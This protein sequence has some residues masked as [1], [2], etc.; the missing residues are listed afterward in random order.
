MQQQNLPK[1]SPP[2]NIKA[3]N[4]PPQIDRMDHLDG[5]Y[6]MGAPGLFAPAA[7]QIVADSQVAQLQE[8]QPIS[9]EQ[10]IL[11][12]VKNMTPYEIVSGMYKSYL[13][14][15]WNKR[16]YQE[17]VQAAPKGSTYVNID[18]NSL[19]AVNDT[20][21]HHAGDDLIVAFGRVFSKVGEKYGLDSLFHVSGDEFHAIAPPGFDVA[22]MMAELENIFQND[23]I[24]LRNEDGSISRWTGGSFGYGYGQNE[25]EAENNLKIAKAKGPKRGEFALIPA[26]GSTVN[27][28]PAVGRSV[29]IGGQARQHQTGGASSVNN[30]SGRHGDSSGR[31][32]DS[33]EFNRVISKPVPSE[34]V[35]VLPKEP[36]FK[37][38]S[39]FGK[40]VQKGEA[41]AQEV[42]DHFQYMLDHEAEIKQSIMDY[43][44]SNDKYKR[45]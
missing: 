38:I 13:T 32:G 37:H 5:K 19:K 1:S 15:L 31:H 35:F 41:T 20:I 11:E 7:T 34:Q 21:G 27:S 40:R 16:A 44:N 36:T 30:A 4:R 8:N 42:R 33:A 3:E 6:F 45:I 22:P 2:N 25:N 10:Q 26:G 12:R 14:G 24:E 9:R 23:I 28:R 18:L 43:I 39:E 29:S 17:A